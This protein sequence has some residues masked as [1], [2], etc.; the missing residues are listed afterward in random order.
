MKVITISC[1]RDNFSYIVLN[2]QNNNACVVDPGEARP[3]I[4]TVIKQKINLK[5]ILNTH[6][7]NDHVG[8]NLELKRQFNCNILG[9][10]HDKD[11]IPGID[12]FIRDTE[13]YQN[14]DFEFKTYHTPGHTEGHVI[15]HFYK[16]NFLFTGD[17]LFSLGCGRIF[18]GSYDQMFNSLNIIKNFSKDTMIYFGHEY[19]KNNSE[20]CLINDPQNN[21]LKSKIKKIDNLLNLGKPTTPTS[22]K[23]ELQSNIFLKSE[24]IETF[25]KLRNLKDNF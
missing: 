3:I 24:N 14:E 5:L 10:I 7:H 13:L 12:I 4:D 15:F 6:H 18:E 22:L 16:Y 1:L 19:T 21:Q 20:F 17:T 23:E 8:G 9:Y 2:E 25:K 11:N